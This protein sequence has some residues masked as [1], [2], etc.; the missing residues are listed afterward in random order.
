[1]NLKSGWKTT[2]FW[3]SIATSL[4]GILTMF[5][6]FTPEKAAA[7]PVAIEQIVGG[8]VAIVPIVGYVLSR[9]KAKAGAVDT[10]PAE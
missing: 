4:A 10:P 2:E 5:G 9:G 6:I 7:L 3:V 1:M 8:V